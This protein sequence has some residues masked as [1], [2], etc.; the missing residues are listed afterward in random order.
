ML[1]V[2]NLRGM[3]RSHVYLHGSSE[4]IGHDNT[5]DGE[6]VEPSSDTY[7]NNVDGY[8]NIEERIKVGDSVVDNEVGGRGVTALLTWKK[9]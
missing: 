5:T 8:E 3:K 2:E 9:T 7:L 1:A 4:N 6:D